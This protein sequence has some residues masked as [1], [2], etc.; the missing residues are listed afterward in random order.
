MRRLQV[1]LFLAL[2]IDLSTGNFTQYSVMTYMGR[3]SEK[4]VAICIT[5]SLCYTEETNNI[6]S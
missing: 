1:V 3:E 5:D 4:R 6:V 2:K